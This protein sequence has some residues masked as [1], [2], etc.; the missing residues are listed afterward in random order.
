MGFAGFKFAASAGERFN[1]SCLIICCATWSCT[2]S[3]LSYFRSMASRHRILSAFT[4][5]SCVVILRSSPS[6]MNVPVSSVSTFRS[7]AT[8]LGSI[9]W[10]RYLSMEYEGRTVS[11]FT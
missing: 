9:T 11:E 5:T 3:S 2:V 6:R 1:S 7:D 4:S 10:S 8:F